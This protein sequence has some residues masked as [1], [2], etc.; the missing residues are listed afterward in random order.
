MGAMWVDGLFP[1][2]YPTTATWFEA[3]ARSG[4]VRLR[5]A[6]FPARNWTAD[7]LSMVALGEFAAMNW[8]DRLDPGPPPNEDETNRE[9][10]HLVELARQQR[11]EHVEEILAQYTDHHKYYLG[12]LAIRQETHPAT[13]LLLKVASRVTELTMAYFKYKYNRAR[14]YQYYPALMPPLDTAVHPSYPNGHA[15]FGLMKAH[16][17]ADAVPQMLEPMLRLAERIWHNAEIGGFHFPSDAAA[18]GKIADGAMELL[19]GVLN[20]QGCESYKRT[21]EAAKLEWQGIRRAI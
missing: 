2:R 13:Y 6:G 10:D 7:M 18:S 11:S 3:I 15:L 14:P 12:L 4:D 5:P 8:R 20:Y 17:V 21:V 19:R 1:D 9:I 16:C